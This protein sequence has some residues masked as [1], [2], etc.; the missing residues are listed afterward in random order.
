MVISSKPMSSSRPIFTFFNHIYFV[1][2]PKVFLLELP[3]LF[4]YRVDLHICPGKATGTTGGRA[5][6]CSSPLVFHFFKWTDD[7]GALCPPTAGKGEE[8]EK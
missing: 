7:D 5:N 2:F 4:V 1:S 8:E 3:S 6:I